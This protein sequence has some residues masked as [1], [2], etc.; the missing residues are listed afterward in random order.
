MKQNMTTEQ[1]KHPMANRLRGFCPIVVDVETGGLDPQNS[2]LLDI[3]ALSL[4]L[5]KKGKMVIDESFE[6]SCIPDE[7]CTIVPEALK[8]NKI[9]LE[10]HALKAVNE[11]KSMRKFFQ[12]CRKAIKKHDC[13]RGI[14]VGH[15]A[16]F[17]LSFI[18]AAAARHG[19]KRNPF[20]PFSVMDTV[21]L[22]GLVYGQTVL[23][24]AAQKA[25]IPFDDA[26][27]HS[28]MYDTRVTA[29]LFCKIH[30]EFKWKV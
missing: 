15:N 7:R 20:H 11:Q 8:I 26:K 13:Q 22:A 21:G 16:N 24:V 25:G 12:F 4:T 6:V 2:A 28:A 14:L 23:K 19:V 3:A 30:N 5:D 1:K 18:T 9:N 29:E 10:E 17:D 27:A